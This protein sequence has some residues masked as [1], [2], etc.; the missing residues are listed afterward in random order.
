MRSRGSWIREFV[1]PAA[2][3]SR[4]AKRTRRLT[5]CSHLAPKRIGIDEVDERPRTV[6]LHDRKPLP[7]PGLQLGISA[8]V[9]LIELER[10]F[11]SNVVQ[12]RASPLAE[13]APLCME[14]D[15]SRDRCRA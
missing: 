9:H 3:L 5:L 11:R 13:M 10:H 2:V 8:D 15:D 4:S 6:D 12:D 1:T 14:E 7:V